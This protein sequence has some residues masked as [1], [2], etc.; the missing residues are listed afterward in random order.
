MSVQVK[1]LLVSPFFGIHGEFLTLSRD[2]RRKIRMKIRRYIY[3]IRDI[4][5]QVYLFNKINEDYTLPAAKII[6]GKHD[7]KMKLIFDSEFIIAC[8][9]IYFT[10]NYET[11]FPKYILNIQT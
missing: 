11:R 8:K 5:I 6:M 10:N 2:L 7:N 9:R 1:T 4:T 3:V